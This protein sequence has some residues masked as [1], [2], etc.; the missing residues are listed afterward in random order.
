MVPVRWSGGPAVVCSESRRP[1]A[2]DEL[3]RTGPAAEVPSAGSAAAVRELS[4]SA[5]CRAAASCSLCSL[6]LAYNYNA[7]S[8]GSKWGG[9]GFVEGDDFFFCFDTWDR[10]V[11]EGENVQM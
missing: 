5:R 9:G 1:S 6:I 11:K 4:P 2:G 10:F 3:W 7:R 8:G